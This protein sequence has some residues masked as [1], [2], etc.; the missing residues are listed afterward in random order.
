M[1]TYE[2]QI[3]IP[4]NTSKDSPKETTLTVE[5]DLLRECLPEESASDRVDNFK[6]WMR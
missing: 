5:G 2:V 1:P 4:K 3:E 6:K